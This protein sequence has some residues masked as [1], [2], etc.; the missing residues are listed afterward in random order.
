VRSRF[1]VRIHGVCRS[2]QPDLAAPDLELMFFII[3]E[4]TWK[5]EEKKVGLLVHVR[6]S[7]C[8]EECCFDPRA[9]VPVNTI[10]IEDAV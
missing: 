1:S 8:A 10:A 3:Q 9:A 5:F 4:R 7:A 2:S 6:K